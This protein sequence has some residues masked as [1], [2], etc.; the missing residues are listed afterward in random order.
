LAYFPVQIAKPSAM[1]WSEID[2]AQMIALEEEV[3]N[4]KLVTVKHRY[5][6]MENKNNRDIFLLLEVIWNFYIG[7]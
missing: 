4:E 7:Y 3:E 5:K 2:W 6:N 1:R